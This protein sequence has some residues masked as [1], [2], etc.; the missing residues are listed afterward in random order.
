MKTSFKLAVA[1][2]AGAAV[3]GIV[4]RGL[5]A[6]TT[7]PTYVVTDISE[8][9]D[10]EGFKAVLAK[11]APS[12]LAEFGGKYII[13]TENIVPVEGVAPKRFVVIAF[14]SLE[15]SRAWLD[16]QNQKEI[17]AIRGK[18][19]KSRQFIVEGM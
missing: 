18:T 4:V 15:K 2:A 10:P 17:R 19:T 7:P 8:I 11:A 6:Q 9:T 5:H 13:R 3:G 14:D 1:L 12:S 16:S